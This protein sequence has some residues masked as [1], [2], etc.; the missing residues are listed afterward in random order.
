MNTIFNLDNPILER[1]QPIADLVIVSVL[2]LVC[3]IPLFT[4]GAASS[5]MYYT[6]VKV[7]RHKRETVW[8]AFWHSFVENL[9][10]GTAF[11]IIYMVEIAAFALYLMNFDNGMHR[12]GSA[13]LMAGIILFLAIATS[14]PYTFPVISRFETRF[15]NQILYIMNM[16]STHIFTTALLVIMLAFSIVLVYEFTFLLLFIPGAY[17]YYSSFLIE[18]VMRQYTL[19]ID[20]KYSDSDVPWYL[21]NNSECDQG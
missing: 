7:I 20:N 8:K 11:T 6:T 2:W 21:E 3:S 14:L 17:T 1:L 16:S 10:Q 18:R 13:Y 9:M 19:R 15:L 4:I 12:F 5:A